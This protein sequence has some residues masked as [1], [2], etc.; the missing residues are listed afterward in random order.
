MAKR[1]RFTSLPPRKYSWK[2]K[3]KSTIKRKRYNKPRLYRSVKTGL[4]F[5]AKITMTH[6]YFETIDINSVSG[7]T[8]QCQFR[9]NGIFDPNYTGVGHQP[10]YYDQMTALYN[11][12]TVIGSK[13][14]VSV[15]H[16]ATNNTNSTVCLYVNDDT[17]IVPTLNSLIEQSK[18][19][20]VVMPVS[21]VDPYRLTTTWS[22][23]KEFGTSKGCLINTAMGGTA[24]ADPSEQSLYSICIFPQNVSSTQT[25]NLEVLI[26]YIVVWTELKDIGGS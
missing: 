24:G 14:T 3:K 26:S 20:F 2:K 25:Y 18:A 12:W 9:A 11:H 7:S 16:A 22:L 5:P 23:K 15:A 4:G 13:I 6:R 21:N 17:S 19:K 10:L 1:M 8:A